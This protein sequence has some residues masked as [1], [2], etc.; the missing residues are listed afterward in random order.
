M[1]E[2][3]NETPRP[4]VPRTRKK[5]SKLQLFK[6]AYL[7]ALI[8]LLA[9]ALVITFVAGAVRRRVV[10]HKAEIEASKAVEASIAAQ[11]EEER[12]KVQQ[13][14]TEAAVMAQKFDYQGALD[15]L[16]TFTGD[17]SEYPSLVAKQA[18][19]EDAMKNL[20][21]YS[22]PAA[23]PNLSFQ[24]LVADPERAFSDETY[25]SAYNRNYVTTDE[26]AKILQQLYDN[27]YMLVK[28]HDLVNTKTDE[29]G[30]VVFE[31]K[32][33]M[34]P[35]GKK[36]IV[37]TQTAAN[38]F[39]YMT[40]SDGDGQPD[41]AG[42][43]FPY[44]L[45]LDE[46]GRFISKMIDADGN[47]VTGAYDFVTILEDFIATHPDFSFN[48]ARAVLAVTGYDGVFGYRTDGKTA[49]A[50]G[51]E[52]HDQ[53]VAGARKVVEALQKTGYE[54]AGYS[55]DNISYTDSDYDTVSYDINA[56]V[57]EVV[58]II[59]SADIFVFPYGDDLTEDLK[60]PYSGDTYQALQKAGFKMFVG[61]NHEVKSDAYVGEQYFRQ[62]R[63][64]VSGSKMAHEP[65]VFED[66]FDSKA[67]LNTG[68]GEIPE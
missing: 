54:L 23:V 68:R 34:L 4:F 46:N 9:L 24:M 26:F 40:D 66:L 35:T 20:S 47:D 15:L 59:D 64:L 11:K 43:G 16:N 45:D 3:T 39:T 17:T 61:M 44:R 53:E 22:D 27:N 10:Q 51:K 6:E 37:L 60:D 12:Q 31:P 55:Y 14:L 32:T 5:R 52:F 28:M 1:D 62:V 49:E 36:P 8:I 56:W 65:E 21:A 2:H 41:A 38:Y 58:P 42:D 7:P 57:Q 63:R 25:G 19:Y 33:L 13:L 29:E 30:N 18:E 67:V 50:K 48:G